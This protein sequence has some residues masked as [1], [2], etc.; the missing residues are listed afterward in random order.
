MLYS[1]YPLF[2]A[3]WLLLDRQPITRLTVF[4]LALTTPAVI[5]L[6]IPGKIRWI[7]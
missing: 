7:C 6:L 4:R 1:F 5:L 2:V 3:M